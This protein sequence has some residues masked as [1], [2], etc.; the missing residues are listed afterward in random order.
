MLEKITAF[1]MSVIM[2]FAG[3]FGFNFFYE[4]YAANNISYGSDNNQKLDMVLP[5]EKNSDGTV[6]LIVLIH[7]GA[8]IEG[9]KDSYDDTLVTCAQ[10]G[11]AAAAIDYRFISDDTHLDA[12]LDDINA[13]LAKI[14]SIAAN[15]GFTINKAMLS[16]DSAGGHLAMLY[17][18]SRKDTAPITPVAVM[19]NSGPSDLTNSD[20]FEKNSIGDLSTMLT[21]MGKASG[22]NISVDDYNAKSDNYYKMIKSLRIYSPVTYAATAVPTVI[23]HGKNDTLVP[24]AT[25]VTLDAKLTEY[26]IKH[27]FVTF[28]NSGHGLENDSDCSKKAGDLMV[29]YAEE[30]LK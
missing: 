13:A 12:E 8:W 7:G 22:T 10:Y 6:G 3:L 26:G 27:D 11:Y 20:M 24:Y 5:K 1:F 30:Y 23:A 28:P 19:S 21:L 14:K 29:S 18:Y 16:G 15:K 4:S 17:S 9:S 2:F 25:A